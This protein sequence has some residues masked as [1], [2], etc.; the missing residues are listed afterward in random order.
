MAFLRLL[1][2]I[3]TPYFDSFFSFITRFGEEITIILLLTVLYWCLDKRL[4]Y[5]IGISFFL[6]GLLVQ[7]LKISFQIDRPWIIDPSFQ[8]VASAIAGATGFSFPSGHTQGAAA[9]F[10]TLGFALKKPWQKFGCFLM[11][12]LVGFSRMYLG[13][14]TPL[15][16][17]VGLVLG[18]G[19]AFLAARYLMKDGTKKR[20]LLLTVGL[21]AAAA[22]TIA[23]AVLMNRSGTIEESYVA[24]CLKAAGAGIGFAAGMYL[25]KTRIRFSTK[26]NKPWMQVVKYLV[27]IIGVLVVKEGLK[28]LLGT[29]FLIDIVRYFMMTFWLTVLFPLII[30]KWFAKKEQ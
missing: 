17:G 29:G 25:E 18:L 14:H 12:A 20:E 11:V 5:G 30:K 8:P 26:C 6:S 1:E 27:G 10:G 24:D 23:I 3:R 22:A 19:I 16:V 4:A 13:V 21:L 2:G 7:V 28:L 15:D 9:L